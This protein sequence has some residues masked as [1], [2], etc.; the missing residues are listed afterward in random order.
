MLPGDR[1]T[2]NSNTIRYG[3][4][5]PLAATKQDRRAC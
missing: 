2:P 5:Q 3:T 4:H 1:A